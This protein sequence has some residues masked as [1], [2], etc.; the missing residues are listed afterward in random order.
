MTS[1]RE[2]GGAAVNHII[3]CGYNKSLIKI[4]KMFEQTE[5]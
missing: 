5:S 2:I 3:S 4:K 1:L